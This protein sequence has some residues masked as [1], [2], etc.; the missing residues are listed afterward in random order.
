MAIQDMNFDHFR[1]KER[2]WEDREG[3]I[4]NLDWLKQGEEL[5]RYFLD[6]CPSCHPFLHRLVTIKLYLGLHDPANW[7]EIEELLFNFKTDKE[8]S[9]FYHYY[10]GILAFMRKD[11]DVAVNHFNSTLLDKYKG[12]PYRDRISQRSKSKYYIHKSNILKNASVEKI[13]PVPTH[14]TKEELNHKS[15]IYF[16]KN[17][18]NTEI[19]QED[20]INLI[21]DRKTFII[22]A[23]NDLFRFIRYNNKIVELPFME[24]LVFEYIIKNKDIVYLDDI[25]QNLFHDWMTP[26][27]TAKRSVEKLRFLLKE[28]LDANIYQSLRIYGNYYKWDLESDWC[29]IYTNDSIINMINND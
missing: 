17:T 12:K 21:R 18:S 2:E 8:N 7:N 23:S 3:I 16:S 27:K 29:F 20:Y 13:E 6:N 10:R 24:G 25:A 26:I 19:T 28:K 9:S 5:Y 11:F 4:N 15:Y 14:V 22:D 1:A